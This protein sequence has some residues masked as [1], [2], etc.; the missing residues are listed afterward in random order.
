MDTW[1]GKIAFAAHWC[2][3]YRLSI[4]VASCLEAIFICAVVYSLGRFA[5][6]KERWTKYFSAAFFVFFV[7]YLFAAGDVYAIE[8]LG[9]NLEANRPIAATSALWIITI[10]SSFNN[11]FIFASGR[12]ILARKR[13]FL[14]PIALVAAAASILD[15]WGGSS[16]CRWHPVLDGLLSTVCLT[17]LG[18]AM[19][20]SMR[21]TRLGSAGFLLFVCTL[22]YGAIILLTGLIPFAIDGG[23]PELMQ[24]FDAHD[25]TDGAAATARELQT[26]VMATV[27]SLKLAVFFGAFTLIVLALA[28]P[29]R[30][31][32]IMNVQVHKRRPLL[33]QSGMIQAFAQ[34]VRADAAEVYLLRT[35]LPEDRIH[36]W[37]WSPQRE[38]GQANGA[39][40]DRPADDTLA[41]RVLRSGTVF[42]SNNHAS[43]EVTDVLSSKNRRS[44]VGCVPIKYGGATIGCLICWWARTNAISATVDL[45]MAQI[46]AWFAP[47]FQSHRYF[48]AS[49]R[50]SGHIHEILNV[51]GAPDGPDATPEDLARALNYM[52]QCYVDPIASG[53]SV[54]FGFSPLG[55][56]CRR[57]PGTRIVP[58]G[59]AC[60]DVEERV[61]VAASDV[62]RAG[63]VVKAIP[64]APGFKDN[65]GESVRL[66]HMVLAVRTKNDAPNHPTLAADPMLQTTVAADVSGALLEQFRRKFWD[67]LQDFHR[68][69][70]TAAERQ[71]T[72][73]WFDAVCSCAKRAGFTWVV[74]TQPGTT[75]LLGDRAFVDTVKCLPKGPTAVAGERGEIRRFTLPAPSGSAHQVIELELHGPAHKLWLGVARPGFGPEL[76]FASAWLTF[77]GRFAEIGGGAIA[78]VFTALEFNKLQ[79][80]AAQTQALASKAITIGTLAHDIGNLMF[81]LT[82]GT[83]RLSRGFENGQL[84]EKA[85]GAQGVS[86]KELASGVMESGERLRTLTQGLLSITALDESRPCRVANAAK[87]AIDLLRTSIALKRIELVVRIPRPLLVDLPNHVMT[88][89][90]G[91]LIQNAIEAAS[92][93]GKIVI[94]ARTRN[95]R[96]ECTVAD[97]GSGIRQNPRDKVFQI[98]VTS[99]KNS[100]G[101]GLF[102]T[103]R[104][105]QSN[106]ATIGLAQ[107]AR[108]GMSTAFVIRARPGRSQPV[109]SN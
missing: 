71:T 46:A 39:K 24:H 94:E 40:V 14:G 67:I 69:L 45:R 103:K 52:I 56:I 88:L 11:F 75:E 36:H 98:G 60:A 34:T 108:A 93:R 79:L 61:E 35:G 15:I 107:K 33:S 73:S 17:Y 38:E 72:D 22:L 51:I 41:G 63:I 95:N 32:N 62:E 37:R 50:C 28:V 102:L 77:L 82:N 27:F 96:V 92:D 49:S 87:Q 26:L 48:D 6:P 85:Q 9:Y 84:I 47:V 1:A 43:E 54:D 83:R 59:V 16:N 74:A 18:Y 66:G 78:Q 86:Y 7:Q 105:L 106:G 21:G 8:E 91:N 57:A 10:G 13:L 70:A 104:S 65:R 12:L 42:T 31:T 20:L 90:I 55:S 101:F 76:D 29:T 25:H 58:D 64:L 23:W 19:W 80:E 5:L 2:D 30:A 97:D 53:V 81:H 68:D 3:E 89:A 100:G 4:V 109:S 44:S 99:K